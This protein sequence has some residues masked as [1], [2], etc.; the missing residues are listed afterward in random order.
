MLYVR[1]KSFPL[2]YKGSRKF[3]KSFRGLCFGCWLLFLV[4]VILLEKLLDFKEICD[5]G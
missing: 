2:D 5:E 3:T 1:E 4:V